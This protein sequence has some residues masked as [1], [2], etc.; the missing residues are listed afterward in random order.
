MLPIVKTLCGQIDVLP[1]P[2]PEA[3][4]DAHFLDVEERIIYPMFKKYDVYSPALAVT[5][6]KILFNTDDVELSDDRKSMVEYEMSIWRDLKDS[7][8]RSK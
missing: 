5:V 2:L 8:T 6:Y 1:L 4:A 7:H 3:T